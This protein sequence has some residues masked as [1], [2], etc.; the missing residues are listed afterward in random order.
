MKVQIERTLNFP[1]VAT[2]EFVRCDPDY[3]PGEDYLDNVVIRI[4]EHVITWMFSATQMELIEK[5]LL[6][7]GRQRSKHED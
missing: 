7:E 3:L 5:V 6:D 4:D 1:V 2:A